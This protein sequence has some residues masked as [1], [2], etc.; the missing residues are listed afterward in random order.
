MS[1]PSFA[2]LHSKLLLMH[3]ILF[4]NKAKTHL[5]G[6]QRV[7]DMIQGSRKQL[8]AILVIAAVVIAIG[9]VVV[10]TIPPEPVNTPPTSPVVH[11]K[12]DPAYD[13]SSLSCDIISPS[14]D[15]DGDSVSYTYDWLRN[16]S[17]MPLT[18]STVPADETAIGDNWTCVV[19]PFDGTDYGPAGKDTIIIQSLIP[20][21]QPPTPPVVK[22]EPAVAYND[23]ALW[24]N[25][26][27][28]SQD[29]ENDSISYEYL[30][31]RNGVATI[32]EDDFVWSNQTA[33]GDNWTCVV[34]PFDGA[35]YGPPGNDTVTI[36]PYDPSGDWSLSPTISYQCAFF[37]DP[38]VDLY[39]T[40][41]TFVDDGTTMIVQPAINGPSFMTGLS[42]KFG[43]IDVML[44]YPGLCT[45]TYSLVGSFINSTFW[46]ATF[47]AAFTGN[48]FDCTTYIIAITGT[49]T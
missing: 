3:P 42:A 2:Y 7:T 36:Q 25:I 47:T 26:T 32:L 1:I 15:A 4:Q 13:D 35:D 11:I 37:P 16:G 21:N 17:S 23:T 22:I 24:C 44:V 8:A 40:L 30:W 6:K 19:T 45:E 5:K 33:I 9:S 43:Q 28:S 29:P 39:Y 38:M 14:Y 34:T 27:S 20:P 12:P 49:R 10:L 18:T 48:C 41:F 31:F 46:E